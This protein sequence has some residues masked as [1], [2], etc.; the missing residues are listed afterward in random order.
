[1]QAQSY[2]EWEC[3]VVDDGSTDDTWEVSLASAHEDE[4]IR[5]LRRGNGGLAAARNSGLRAATGAYVQFLDADDAIEPRKLEAQV[6]YLERRPEIGIVYGDVRYFESETGERR[7]AL[8]NDEDWMPQVSGSGDGVMRA[9][10]RSN[11]MVVSSPLLRRSVVDEV[12]LFDETLTSLE[13]WDYWIRCAAAGTSFQYLDDEGTL[14]LVRVHRRSMSQNR[15]EMYEQ[16]V[17][18]R[19]AMAP[20]V[21]GD[22]LTWQ[23]RFSLA[24]ELGRLGSE[25]VQRGERLRGARLL[26]E[27]AWT[28]PSSGGGR[29]VKQALLALLPLR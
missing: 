7:R 19:K 17:K 29:W 3:I 10:I 6:E 15:I 11:I 8:F 13:D 28:N 20:T 12:G 21:T 4:R 25:L 27:A 5:Y 23:N 1:M 16:Q 18:I 24:Q 22:E 14:A 9:L 26:V 2:S